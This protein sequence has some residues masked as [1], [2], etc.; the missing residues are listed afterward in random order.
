[1]PSIIFQDVSFYYREPYAEV[2]RDVSLCLDSAW[3]TGLIG[4]NGR[5]KTTFLNLLCTRSTPSG[6]HVKTPVAAHYFPYQPH[7]TSLTTRET[8]KDAVAPFRVWESEM[9]RCLDAGRDE[10]LARYGSI[11]TRFE[12]HG[13]YQIDA[14]IEKAFA[15]LGLPADSLERAFS[16][17]S[18]GEQT[19]ALIVALFVRDDALA[20]I[21][22]PT[23]HLDMHGRALLASYL[24]DQ[25]RGYILVSHDRYLLDV[26]CD[27][28]VS[29]N[30]SGFELINGN[31][32]VWKEQTDRRKAHE[33]RRHDNLERDIKQLKRAASQRRG[34]GARKE[35]DKIRSARQGVCRLARGPAHET[36]CGNR[37]PGRAKPGRETKPSARHREATPAKARYR[38]D[39]HKDLTDD[40]QSRGG[41]RRRQRNSRLVVADFGRRAR[42]YYRSERVW[43]DD[44]A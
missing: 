12:E 34:A 36:G 2:F 43:Q 16:T 1:M 27:H 39:R 19:R 44:I 28:V 30:K 31:Y 13:G 18:G 33:Q 24:R 26:C 14:R 7:D 15:E 21:D 9:R 42:G 23:N 22:E 41:H 10:D 37:A 32:T 6:G 20:L 40:Q 8:V 4:R 29:I 38:E 25:P 5:G 35:K 3:K 17:L 11:A